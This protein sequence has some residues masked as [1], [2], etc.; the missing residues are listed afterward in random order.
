MADKRECFAGDI[1]SDAIGKTV[2]VTVERERVTS[3]LEDTVKEVTHYTMQESG[4]P[5]TRIRFHHTKWPQAGLLGT[6]LGQSTDT[7]LVLED[8]H[9]VEV[10]P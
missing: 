5:F 3:T 2:R 9:L 10:L 7:G 1:T 6:T 4:K 8:T